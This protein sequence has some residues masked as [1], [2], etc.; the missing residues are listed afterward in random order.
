M[1]NESSRGLKTAVAVSAAFLLTAVGAGTLYA[2]GAWDS[3][4]DDRSLTSAC[5]GLLDYSEAREMLG[6]DRLRAEGD[7]NKARCELSDPGAGKAS[8]NVRIQRDAD[9]VRLLSRLDRADTHQGQKMVTPM[10]SG[11][12]GVLNSGDESAH[13]A[14]WLSCQKQQDGMILVSVSAQRNATGG[15]FTAPE[16]EARLARVTTQ[17]LAN[18]AKRWGCD[19]ELGSRVEQV[20]AGSVKTLKKSGAA[21]GT[22]KGVGSAT[23]E[24]AAD[25]SAPIEDCILATDTSER[26]FRVSAYYGPF[27]KS[28]RLETTRGKELLGKSGGSDGLYWTTAT[29]GTSIA[30]YSVEPLDSG[31]GLVKPQ[32]ESELQALKV[33]A[34]QSAERHG[35]S[36]PAGMSRS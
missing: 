27:V 29:C 21:T 32:P 14:A 35:C 7:G 10:G 30:L 3:W 22:C 17:T 20:P 31:N 2:T 19:A 18:A 26:Q 34:K 12:A 23:F 8:L 33:F 13:A 9:D 4:Q 5:Q 6:A 1:A 15:P 28:A 11:W 16:Q 25:G 24:A 36:V